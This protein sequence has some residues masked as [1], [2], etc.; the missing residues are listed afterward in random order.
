VGLNETDGITTNSFFDGKVVS[1][2]SAGGIAGMNNGLIKNSAASGDIFSEENC[3]GDLFDGDS[4]CSGLLVGFNNTGTLTFSVSIANLFGHETITNAADS[5]LPSVFPYGFLEYLNKDITPGP[6]QLDKCFNGN[7]PFSNSSFVGSSECELVPLPGIG[8]Y[9]PALDLEL[10]KNVDITSGFK[11]KDSVLS[12]NTLQ[13][14]YNTSESKIMEIISTDF[15]LGTSRATT[16]EKQFPIQ[17]RLSGIPNSILTVW[18]KTPSEEW[19]EIGN[20]EF[21][22]EGK[23]IL[24]AL[25]FES[26][27]KYTLSFFETPKEGELDPKSSNSKGNVELTII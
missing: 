12:Q 14:I 11:I 16:L 2:G 9:I 18:I 7:R 10:K 23:V 26:S 15:V 3:A 5:F 19:I 6:W 4:T 24:P 1:D 17:L 8:D 25:K 20:I 21:D 13:L 27:G 22:K